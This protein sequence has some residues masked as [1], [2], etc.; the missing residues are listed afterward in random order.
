M[1]ETGRRE[2]ALRL[3]RDLYLRLLELVH[4]GEIEVPLRA[5]LEILVQLSDAQQG[6]V[7]LYD[8]GTHEPRW[9]V[10]HQLSA[11]EVGQVRNTISTGIVAAAIANGQTILTAAALADGRFDARES[12]RN[13]RIEAVLCVPIGEDPVCGVL[14]LQGPTDSG[15][16]TTE[17]RER[18]ETVA[19]YLAPVV[20]RIHSTSRDD[21]AADP[22]A[23]LRRTLR[24][25]GII[26]RSTALAS[27]LRQVALAAPLDVSVLLT[28]ESGTGKSQLARVIHDN[29]P[30]AAFPFIEVSCGALPDTLIESELFGAL[31]GAHSTASRRI[32][33]KVAAAQHGTLFLDEVGN[34]SLVAQTKLLQLLQS[35]EYFPLGSPRA[36]R[37]DVRVIAATNSDLER[38]VAEGR[39]REDL[40]YRLHVLPLRV[41]SLAHRREDIADLARH[42]CRESCQ[43]HNLPPIILSR[44][45]LRAAQ[46]ES[47]PGNIRHLAN[48]IEAATIRAVAEGAEQVEVSHLFPGSDNLPE[49]GEPRLT[50]QAAMRRCQRQVVLETLQETNWNVLETSR[51]LDVTRSH[52]YNLIRVFGLSLKRPDD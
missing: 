8:D 15:V 50:L 16:A 40:F 1:G 12:V 27:V 11:D 20:D 4:Q 49:E 3:E 45:A 41:P 29:S 6:Y 21:A 43:R 25:E 35:H 2:H 14:Y 51:R 5:A 10:A 17:S 28:G 24:M 47:W 42:F 36:V 19:R 23:S 31:P 37:A 48:S 46:S 18:A 26:G 13:R 7:E 33:G 32:D 34:L 39:F 9:S 52:I 38:D 30:R 44:N 22:T